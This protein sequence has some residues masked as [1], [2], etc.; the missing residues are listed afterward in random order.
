LNSPSVA[1]KTI[2]LGTGFEISISNLIDLISQKT[3]KELV[4]T[5]SSN[6]KRPKAS[7]VERLVSDNSLALDILDW[8]PKFNGMEGLNQGLEKTIDWFMDTKNLANYPQDNYT[9]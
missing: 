3:G 2:N 5:Q 8:A 9:I 4:I 1:G 7:E 6:R